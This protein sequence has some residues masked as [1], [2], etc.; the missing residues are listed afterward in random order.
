VRK[1][2]ITKNADLYS[3]PEVLK[4]NEYDTFVKS[5]V[6][7]NDRKD[8]HL[9]M[10]TDDIEGATMKKLIWNGRTG[11]KTKNFFP[12]IPN[13]NQYFNKLNSGF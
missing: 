10:R 7:V 6:N 4:Y 8:R 9:N 1:L 2:D 5:T 11:K 3:Y 13:V 12:E